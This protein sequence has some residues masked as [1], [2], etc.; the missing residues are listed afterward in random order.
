MG[1]ALAAVAR[2]RWVLGVAFASL[3]LDAV[4]APETLETSYGIP[5]G[6]PPEEWFNETLEGQLSGEPRP[7]KLEVSVTK[8]DGYQAHVD[9]EPEPEGRPFRR[10]LKGTDCQEVLT[11][12]ALGLAL[13]WDA[14]PPEEDTSPAESTSEGPAL[15][16]SSAA[17][18]NTTLPGDTVATETT[19]PE[20]TSATAASELPPPD[21]PV[22]TPDVPGAGPSGA[23]LWS[24]TGGP[25]WREGTNPRSDSFAALTLEVVGAGDGFAGGAYAARFES[26]WGSNLQGVI[27]G[28]R[29]ERQWESRWWLVGSRG[30]PWGRQLGPMTAS[31]C[32]SAM[33]GRYHAQVEASSGSDG[34][35]SRIGAGPR[36]SLLLR[37]LHLVLAGGWEVP[38]TPT[39]IAFRD[40]AVYSQEGGAVFS[41]EVGFATGAF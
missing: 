5:A 33:V 15:P 7:G 21:D 3:P 22:D 11:A 6:C 34:T 14:L 18:E 32:A 25:G 19:L 36:V 30:C 4:A 28:D 8:S 10:E 37:H 40:V 31:L 1:L 12:L 24:M 29:S 26:T 13:H 16:V 35:A 9:F 38:L 39:Q 20:T 41:V 23:W 2:W 27:P 17:T